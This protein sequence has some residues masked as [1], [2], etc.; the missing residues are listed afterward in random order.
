MLTH[1]DVVQRYSR[2]GQWPHGS[3]Q[4]L[5]RRFYLGRFC[6]WTR[7]LDREDIPAWAVI[8]VGTL[9]STDWRSKFAAY[10]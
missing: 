7:V 3:Y 10:L 9:G 2:R 1:K 8:Q 6:V 5:Q 4:E